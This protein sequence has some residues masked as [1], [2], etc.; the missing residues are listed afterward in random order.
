[1]YPNV[2]GNGNDNGITTIIDK[3]GDNFWLLLIFLLILFILAENAVISM[4]WRKRQRGSEEESGKE[5]RVEPPE[6][7]EPTAKPK[8]KPEKES[9]AIAAASTAIAKD[10]AAPSLTS[11]FPLDHGY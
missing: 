7:E 10:S 4:V 3:T 11:E 2:N 9:I 8:A 1:M 6:T 5:E